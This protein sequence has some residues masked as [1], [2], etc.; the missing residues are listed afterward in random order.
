MPEVGFKS[1]WHH[2]VRRVY[3]LRHREAGVC[4]YVWLQAVVPRG[5][6]RVALARKTAVFRV[7]KKLVASL[8]ARVALARKT[9]VFRVP[10]K[11]VTSGTGGMGRATSECSDDD[12]DAWRGGAGVLLPHA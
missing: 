1:R 12:G 9:A 7:P 2:E 6:G 8:S 4:G 5:P 3:S 11:L 10:R